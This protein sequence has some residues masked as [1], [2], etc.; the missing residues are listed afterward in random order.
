MKPHCPDCNSEYL[1]QGKDKTIL[2]H[3]CKNI[4]ELMNKGHFRAV[5]ITMLDDMPPL[6]GPEF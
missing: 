6:E 4:F 3:G 5:P 1:D 2:C